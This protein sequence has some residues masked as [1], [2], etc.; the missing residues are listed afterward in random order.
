MTHFTFLTKAAAAAL[1]C[2]L[3]AFTA[4]AITPK[5]AVQRPLQGAALDL[6]KTPTAAIMAG[7]SAADST[8]LASYLTDHGFSVTARASRA[9]VIIKSD[10]TTV[11]GSEAY[12]LTVKRPSAV[13]T[14]ADAAGAFYGIQAL[15]DLMDEH[16]H[17]I[18]AQ[19]IADAP[20]YGYRGMMLDVSR[21]P[22]SAEFILKQIRAM[23]R[24]NLNRLHL[25]LTDAAGWRIESTRYPRLN[26][27][28]SWRPEATW[29]EWSAAGANYGGSNGGYLTK[30]ELRHIVD[31]AADRFI[32][33]IPEVE[34][35]SHSEEVLAAYPLLACTHTEKGCTNFCAGSEATF[36]FLTSVLDEV[37]DIFPSEYIHIG[38]DEA[39]KGQWQNCPACQERM[40]QENLPSADHLQSWMIRRIERHL[41][42]HGRKAIVWD[43][44]MEGD[45][46]SATAT[47]MSWKGTS[48][49]DVANPVILTPGRWCYLDAYQDAPHTQP[50]AIGGY[51]PL[52][53]LY[54]AFTPHPAAAGVQG[55]LWCEYIPTDSHAE[56][57]LYPRMIAIAEHAW[58]APEAKDST[59]GFR[60][61]ALAESH[62]MAAE[63]YGVFPLE[64][65][66]GNRP[67]AAAPMRH[68][69][70]GKPV[71][72]LQPYWHRYPSG[73]PTALTD[74]VCGGWNY[75]DGL[76]QGFMQAD[77][78][79]RLD[80][81]ID[82]GSDTPVSAIEASFMQLVGCDVF[83][84]D[85]VSISAGP[86]PDALTELRV[87]STPR[88]AGSPDNFRLY[89]WTGSVTARY[90]RYRATAA[91]GVLFTD[92]IIVK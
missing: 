7:F 74:G 10:S 62:R 15:M 58:T 42:K 46:P 60:S 54:S 30:E 80:V 63:G 37:M 77:S 12:T 85:S 78:P 23:E 6:G 66:T 83:F 21:H 67:D 11:P 24:L 89:G 51:T 25:H 40:R 61:R 20:R 36:E 38:G 81:L 69:A 5:P 48:P 88:D 18:P 41:A 84:P 82:L 53:S 35:P 64:S 57:M 72:Y 13:I 34:L 44:A 17:R 70:A 28:A 33:V 75:N 59:T 8:R 73:G 31:Y 47:V 32:T 14:G 39:P 92:E 52:D 3:T 22:R 79:E 45:G 55:N 19:H 86:A 50:E 16:G 68:L 9:R 91:S 4:P 90:V 2:S 26:T 65:E 29:K 71:T 87:I 1:L 49:A 43:D 27:V 76:W 56:Y